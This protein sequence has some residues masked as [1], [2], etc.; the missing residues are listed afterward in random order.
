MMPRPPALVLGVPISD[1]TMGE[2]LDQIATLVE[3][4]RQLGTTHQ[5]ATVNVDFLVNALGD[6]ALM[7]ILRR[8]DICL[9]DGT[10]IVWGARLLGTPIAERVAGA[11][12]VPLLAARSA[13]TRLRVHVF[14]SSPDV[15]DRARRLIHDRHPD[16]SFSIDPGPII[17]D[18][19]AIDD[20]TLQSIIDID[21][22]VLCVALGNPK[23]E[24]FIAAHR[25]RLGTP[26]MIGVGGSLDMLVGAR[27][28]APRWMHRTG[29]E[30]VYRAAQEPRRLGSR[31]AHDIRVF[32]PTFARALIR[33]RRS[34][35]G[36]PLVLTVGDDSVRAV[37]DTDVDLVD[38]ATW[39]DANAAIEAGARLEIAFGA[40]VPDWAAI[41][42]IVGLLQVARRCGSGVS[43]SASFDGWPAEAAETVAELAS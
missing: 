6:P 8:A 21:P 16:A 35:R 25:E 17:D 32:V 2:S 40:C 30:W 39:T 18:P 33:S 7:S 26:V 31:Y 15:A 14:G 4:G 12:L 11:D 13:E 27:R 22:D 20:A 1:L 23:Q 29:L 42:T 34:R 3:R 10:P 9:A 36:A 24:R 5:I 19:G 38:H 28:R 43:V 37:V 41:S